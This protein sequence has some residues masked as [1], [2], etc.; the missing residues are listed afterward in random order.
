M[1]EAVSKTYEH[2]INKREEYQF[3]F[4]HEGDDW[5]YVWVNV[6][7]RWGDHY[8][9]SFFGGDGAL[10]PGTPKEVVDQFEKFISLA[11]Q[12]LSDY[13]EAIKE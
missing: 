9:F 7:T 3:G 12:C 6:G 5:S 11:Q 10:S 8:D 2:A 4:E 13:K 1:P